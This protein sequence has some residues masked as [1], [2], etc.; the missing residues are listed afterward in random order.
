MA[1]YFNDLKECKTGKI[2]IA[3]SPYASSFLIPR[4][5]KDFYKKYPLI[6]LELLDYSSIQLVQG[7]QK[8]DF[9]IALTVISVDTGIFE[10]ESVSQEEYVLVVPKEFEVN[11]VLHS[12]ENPQNSY[13]YPI[14]DLKLLK[15]VP[16]ITWNQI[17][18]INEHFEK[19]CEISEIHPRRIIECYSSHPMF[20]MVKQGIGAAILPSGI[21]KF[22][23]EYHIDDD[24]YIY[25]LL[26][27]NY[28][29]ER[30]I[31]YKKGKYLT[32]PMKYLIQLIKKCN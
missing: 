4:I 31:V 32:K 14:V 10:V 23:R 21:V 27:N 28:K 16:F 19:L 29:F 9:D 11:S 1:N 5:L 15:D 20:Q 2:K 7:A 25:R 3:L 6:D 22:M 26:Q 13:I 17:S 30:I 18:I 8:G 12:N 24:V